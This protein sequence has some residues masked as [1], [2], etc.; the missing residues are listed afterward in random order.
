MDF[1]HPCRRHLNGALACPGCGTPVETLRVQ[2][3]PEPA[4]PPGHGEGGAGTA[5]DTGTVP[6]EEPA[7]TLAEE[8]AGT[9]AQEP[10]EERA[11]ASGGEY[12]DGTPPGRR[13]ARRQGRGRGSADE[14][15]SEGQSRRDRKAAA[16]RRR[17]NRTLLIAAG[18]VLAAGALSLAELG[19][20]IPGSKPEPAVAGEESPDGGSAAGEAEASPPGAR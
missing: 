17:R 3:P 18:F 15:P 11:E 5:G 7:G 13:A 6:A 4:V 10:A 8:P 14:D 20:E 9:L 12:G 2:Q 19:L 16:H 1:C